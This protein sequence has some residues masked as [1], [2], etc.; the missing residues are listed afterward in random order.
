MTATINGMVFEGTTD[1]VMAIIKAMSQPQPSAG[2]STPE[3]TQSTRKIVKHLPPKEG[4]APSLS[5]LAFTCPE[6][7]LE[8][9]F[10]YFV[11]RPEVWSKASIFWFRSVKS[12][13]KKLGD[14]LDANSFIRCWD[15]ANTYGTTSAVLKDYELHV[16]GL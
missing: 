9:M 5:W 14:P 1:E 4:E 3:V 10:K 2:V 16:A 12:R 13:C 15:H 11:E 6:E 8:R 7:K